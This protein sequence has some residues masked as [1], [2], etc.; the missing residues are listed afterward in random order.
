MPPTDESN[1]A[2]DFKSNINTMIG[3]CAVIAFPI[4]VFTTRFGTWGSRH[5]GRAAMI[6]FF[7]PPV[8][9]ALYG[10]H[11]RIGSVLAFWL[12]TFVFLLLHRVTGV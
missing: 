1:S 8:F 9:A 5:L 4:T 3:I 12:A 6:G 7:W 10:P 11:P 2:S